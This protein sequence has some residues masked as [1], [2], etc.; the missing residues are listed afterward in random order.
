MGDVEV[1]NGFSFSSSAVA[2]SCS[3][4][5]MHLAK[6]S[7]HVLDRCS[8]A[9]GGCLDVAIWNSAAK[10]LVYSGQGGL[11]VPISMTVAP[12]LQISDFIP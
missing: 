2:R 10:L 7:A 12:T 8:G 11:P 1:I 5:V 6:K 3:S 4:I 9:G